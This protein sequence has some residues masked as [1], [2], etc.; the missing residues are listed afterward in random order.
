MLNRLPPP[1]P[2]PKTEIW[3]LVFQSY[4]CHWCVS[5]IQNIALKIDVRSG[6]RKQKYFTQKQL[7]DNVRSFQVAAQISQNDYLYSSS[8]Y[9]LSP[10][11][12]LIKKAS[13]QCLTNEL[14]LHVNFVK[15]FFSYTLLFYLHFKCTNL[16]IGQWITQINTNHW[17]YKFITWFMD[18]QRL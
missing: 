9:I 8:P 7:L 15:L 4:Y 3:V 17:I 2:P 14:K 18:S 11:P 16:L 6:I 12:S 13:Y 1:P 10:F 5:N